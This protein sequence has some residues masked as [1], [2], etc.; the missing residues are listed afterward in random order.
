[1][2][3]TQLLNKRAIINAKSSRSA[4][5]LV[6]CLTYKTFHYTI[7]LS[8][9]LELPLKEVQIHT[10]RYRYRYKDTERPKG[11]TVKKRR[12]SF[13]AELWLSVCICVYI[14]VCV[15]QV[16]GMFHTSEPI[17]GHKKANKL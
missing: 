12:Q 3:Q 1:M 14:C 10:D 8:E 15:A 5:L 2:T 11:M 9:R 17:G 6:S 7:Q 13:Y 4:S 16:E